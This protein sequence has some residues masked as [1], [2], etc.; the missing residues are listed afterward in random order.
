MLVWDPAEGNQ[1]L[2][3]TS[4]YTVA[5]GQTACVQV[6]QTQVLHGSQPCL[7]LVIWQ[8]SASNL[9]TVP[10]IPYTASNRQF[11]G[12]ERRSENN[13]SSKAIKIQS[14]YTDQVRC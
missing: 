7:I 6:P 10:A 4:A 8:S 3:S 11:Q 13:A 1:G 2:L 12:A 14:E 5:F 9:I